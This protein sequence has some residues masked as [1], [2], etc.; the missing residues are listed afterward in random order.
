MSDWRRYDDL[1]IGQS[2]PDA[3]Y[4]YAVTNQVAEGFRELTARSRLGEFIEMA[5]LETVPPMLAAVY[6][7]GAQDALKGP[8]GGIHAKQRFVF[9]AKIQIG[10][11]LE[12]TLTIKEKY[13]KKGRRYIVFETHTMNQNGLEVTKGEI[14]SIWGQEQ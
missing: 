7:R 5:Q 2:F 3:P 13:E 10:D 4:R 6:I 12:T 8:P 9:L 1:R 14:V 11:V